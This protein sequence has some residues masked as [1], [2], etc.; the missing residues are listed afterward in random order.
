MPGPRETFSLASDL[1]NRAG[2]G[3]EL[4]RVC[5]ELV[6]DGGESSALGVERGDQETRAAAASWVASP[7]P[8]SFN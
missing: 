5:A 3:A 7:T 6:E 4:L 8:V 1:E 2:R